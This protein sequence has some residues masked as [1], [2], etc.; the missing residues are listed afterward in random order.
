M[1]K[2]VDNAFV[3]S[4]SQKV[5]AQSLL[6]KQQSKTQGLGFKEV[7]AKAEQAEITITKHA[8]AR[9]ETRGI[10]LSEVEITKLETAMDKAKVK[11]I[12]EAVIVMDN[13]LLVASVANKTIITAAKQ[14]DIEAKMITNI[15]GAIFI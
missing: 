1:T 4:Q 2:R 7:F 14:N 15:D 11:G 9:L 13:K 5:N 6:K 10:N 12:K 3:L 8:K